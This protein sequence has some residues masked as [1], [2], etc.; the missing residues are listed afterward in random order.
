MK[1][2]TLIV[3]RNR[4]DLVDELVDNISTNNSIDNDI[5]VIECGTDLKKL[6]NNSSLWYKDD[7][8]KGKCFGHNI[9]LDF[10]RKSD[11]YDY[12]FV[13]M[14]DVFI[15]EKQPLSQMI[16]QFQQNPRLAIL[17]PTNLDGGYPG[18]DRE[19]K[20]GW[21][22]VTTCDYLC[23][24]MRA[25]A[26]NDAGFLNPDFKY[27]WG[28]IHELSYKLY[29]KDWFIAYSDDY[30]YKHL[31]G[32]TYGA[33]NTHTISRKEY[34]IRAKQFAFK[35]FIDNY[36]EDWNIKFWDA[37]KHHTIK[38][39]TYDIHRKLWATGLETI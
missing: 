39:N 10:A 21:R 9:A 36:G 14:N 18:S 31:G 7:D 1:I 24:L 2:A 12:F 23:F 5:Y 3:S 6:S 34:Q 30:T 32:S 29:S 13:C 22:K 35:Y 19:K 33:K 4:P 15:Q 37:A 20:G 38:H 25:E 11:E 16:E 26:I 28:A 17:S 27:C 8:F